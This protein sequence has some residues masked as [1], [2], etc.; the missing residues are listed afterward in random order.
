MIE[1]TELKYRYPASY[2][3][4]LIVCNVVLEDC[5]VLKNVWLCHTEEVGYFLIFPSKHLLYNDLEKYNKDR[6]ID[7]VHPKIKYIKNGAKKLWEEFY[8]PISSDFYQYLL[9]TIVEGYESF[10]DEISEEVEE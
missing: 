2:E 4:A 9:D 6:G 10:S 7:I 8:Y 1:V 5:L 3:N